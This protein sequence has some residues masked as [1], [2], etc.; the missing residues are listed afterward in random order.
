MAALAVTGCDRPAA[1]EAARVENPSP[2]PSP[3][4]DRSAFVAAVDAVA[5]EALQRGPIAGLSI[6]VFEHG[7]PVLAKGYGFADIEEQIAP[8]RT[9]LIR[10]HPCPSTSRPRP[11]CA[12]PIRA[13]SLSTIR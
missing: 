1:T 7:R 3:S 6:A 12:W 10:S 13:A 5:A 11:S 2:S 9:P 4:P 8:P